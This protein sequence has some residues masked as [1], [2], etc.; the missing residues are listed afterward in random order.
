MRWRRQSF[1]CQMN[2]WGFLLRFPSLQFVTRAA[3]EEKG[4]RRPD[5]GVD[6]GTLPGFEPFPLGEQPFPARI[7]TDY[8]S[9]FYLD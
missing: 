6:F 2:T 1:S 5:F 7:L 8:R 4:K 3:C 9:S